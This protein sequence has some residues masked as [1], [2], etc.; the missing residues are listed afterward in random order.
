[1]LRLEGVNRGTNL[2]VQNPYIPETKKYCIESVL[3]NGRTQDLN[4]ESSAMQIQLDHMA[5]NANVLLEI[6]YSGDCTPRVLNAHVIAPNTGFKFIQTT[7]DNA[8]I[9]WVTTGEIPKQGQMRVE[10]LKLDGWENIKV[11]PAKGN[12]DTNQYSQ[13]VGHYSG[14]N[15]FRIVYDLNGTEVVS[16]EFNFYS[17]L[18]PISYFP[19]DEVYDLLSLSR[20]TDYK[21]K[22]LDGKVVMEG[23]AMDIN[24]EALE[25]GEYLLIIENRENTFYK[26][27]PEKD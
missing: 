27:E 20:I 13:A 14:D 6:S 21:I 17:A 11:V 25:H 8:S 1:M 2:F 4:L 16:E 12:I 5:L 24:V 18:D 26:P 23:I 19:V 15:V 9:S 7:V 10:K 3:L 22:S